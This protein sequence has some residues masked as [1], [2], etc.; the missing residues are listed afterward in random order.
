MNGDREKA[1][2]L[3]NR[4]SKKGGMSQST[5]SENQRISGDEHVS[6]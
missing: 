6:V 4:L 5:T 2:R 3:E 1:T